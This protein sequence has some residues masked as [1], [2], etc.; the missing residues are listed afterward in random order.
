MLSSA[1][2]IVLFLGIL[3]LHILMNPLPIPA[4]WCYVR[5][6]SVGTKPR[7]I[8][9]KDWRLAMYDLVLKGGTVIDASSGFHGNNDIAIQHG[10]IAHIAP[11]IARE[12]TR[13]VVEVAGAVWPPGLIASP[14]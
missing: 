1:A 8:S 10:K 9:H 6:L 2:F 3:I 5:R 11:A 14:A 13:R 7:G 4:L 12:E